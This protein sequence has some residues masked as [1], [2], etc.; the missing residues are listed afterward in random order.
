MCA[1]KGFL[2]DS[3]SSPTQTAARFLS[4]HL[5]VKTPD[6]CHDPAICAGVPRTFAL[7]VNTANTDH[8]P[9]TIWLPL[10][11]MPWD[12]PLS[13]RRLQEWPGFPGR[14]ETF[15]QREG[16]LPWLPRLCFGLPWQRE[17]ELWP[18]RLSLRT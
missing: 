4:I 14:L 5:S 17:K 6:E 12:H 10:V 11:R 18:P 9:S 8:D 1:T 3:L 15:P 13:E 16:S 2:P 7:D